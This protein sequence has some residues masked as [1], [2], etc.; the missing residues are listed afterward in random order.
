[1]KRISRTSEIIL[2][3]AFIAALKKLCSDDKVLFALKKRKYALVHRLAMY[4]E[5]EVP[6]NLYAD[7]ML[8]LENEGNPDILIHNRKGDSRLAIYAKEAYLTKK[9]QEEAR[10]YHKSQGCMTLAFAFLPEKDYFLVYRF[11]EAFTDYL[12]ISKED[13]HESLLKRCGND[14]EETFSDEQLLLGIK[15]KKRRGKKESASEAVTSGI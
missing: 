15:A 14:S 3:D 12:H 4:L 1:M 13:F 2:F 9:D 11:G 8:F 6:S 5:A 7:M 10:L